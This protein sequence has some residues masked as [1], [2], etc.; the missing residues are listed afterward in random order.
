MQADKLFLRS[1]PSSA[2]VY[3]LLEYYLHLIKM[4]QSHAKTNDVFKKGNINAGLNNR[5][6]PLHTFYFTL[7]NHGEPGVDSIQMKMTNLIDVVIKDQKA[8]DQQLL[9]SLRTVAFCILEAVHE[10]SNNLGPIVERI[11]SAKNQTKLFKHD[12]TDL[13]K[14]D[15]SSNKKAQEEKK[16][17]KEDDGKKTRRQQAGKLAKKKK[18]DTARGKTNKE[19]KKKPARANKNLK[20][21]NTKRTTN[22]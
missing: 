18:E 17:D 5:K 10:T 16:K 3:F 6:F 7:R 15:A 1:N 8:G 21:T 14:K 12:A 11:K 2:L 9:L 22:L 4:L 13:V 19:E 20:R